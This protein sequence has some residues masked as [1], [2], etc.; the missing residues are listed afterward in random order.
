MRNLDRMALR[1]LL[2]VF[3]AALL[4]FVMI[5]QLVELFSHLVRFLELEVPLS[6]IAQVQMLY[7]PKSVSFALPIALLFASSFTLGNHYSNNELIA[8]FSAGISLYRFSAPI[9]AMGLLLSVG[10]F[11]FEERVV[12]DSY[13]RQTQMTESLLNINRSFNNTNVAA[14]SQDNRII[15]HA[16]YYNDSRQE[17]NGVVILVR[18]GAGRL[19]ERID[20]DR[21]EWRDAQWTLRDV[22]R[23]VQQEDGAVVKTTEPEY[24][25]EDL[26]TPPSTFQRKTRDVGSMPLE[27]AREYVA[28]MRRAGLPYRE[29]LTTYYERYSFALTP[30]IVTLIAAAIGGRFKKNVLLMSLLVSLGLTVVYYVLGML[31][32]LFAALGAVPPLVGAWLGV[33]AFLVLSVALFRHART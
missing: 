1:T 10:S 2:P 14:L 13:R 21:A 7:V 18:D 30:L 17:L 3:L 20:A 8:V 16:N 23:F 28:S 15:Y 26:V 9:I 22:R 25:R 12:I 24:R 6:A 4:F 31:S 5:L 27:E 33:V 11:F 19:T 32:S 29:M